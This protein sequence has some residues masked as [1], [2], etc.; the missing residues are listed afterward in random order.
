M[1]P[2]AYTGNPIVDESR[3]IAWEGYRK[4]Y[5]NKYGI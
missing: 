2:L 4:G 1:G 5:L 3:K